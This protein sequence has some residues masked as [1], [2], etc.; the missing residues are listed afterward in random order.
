MFFQDLL[1]E[2]T[3]KQIPSQVLMRIQLIIPVVAATALGI[4]LSSCNKGG[5]V[6]MAAAIRVANAAG[7]RHNLGMER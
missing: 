6:S 1:L 7:C 2:T 3:P 4:V 5:D